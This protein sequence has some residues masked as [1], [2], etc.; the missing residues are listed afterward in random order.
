MNMD[1]ETISALIQKILAGGNTSVISVLIINL[2]G[3]AGVIRFLM[4]D[5]SRLLSLVKESDE[6]YLTLLDKYHESTNS[7]IT[8]ITE[9]RVVLAEIKGNNNRK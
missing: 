4:M 2:L 8:A 5:R 1:G 7:M 3:C 9:L 6:K